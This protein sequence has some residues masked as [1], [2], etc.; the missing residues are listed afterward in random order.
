MNDD[1]EIYTLHMTDIF[2]H[3]VMTFVFT[4]TVDIRVDFSVGSSKI[5]IIFFSFMWRVWK[6]SRSINRRVSFR[7]RLVW[8]RI[9]EI[10]RIERPNPFRAMRMRIRTS[11]STKVVSRWWYTDIRIFNTDRLSIDIFMCFCFPFRQIYFADETRYYFKA[12]IT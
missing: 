5:R 8:K 11:I 1:S 12:W 4:D 3:D 7:D 9:F 2:W 6:W 10:V